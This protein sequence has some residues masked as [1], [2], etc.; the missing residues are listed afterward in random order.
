MNPE[1][2][3][4]IVAY[5]LGIRQVRKL[6]GVFFFVILCADLVAMICWYNFVI[7]YMNSRIFFPISKIILLYTE[8]FQIIY[9]SLKLTYVFSTRTADILK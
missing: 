7:I 1:A 6:I 8:L 2:V 3:D 5:R 9:K 4:R